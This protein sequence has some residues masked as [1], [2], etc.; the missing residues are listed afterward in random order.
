MSQ[1]KISSSSR[2][3]RD[4]AFE[5]PHA[6]LSNKIWQFKTNSIVLKNSFLF[7]LEF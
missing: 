7:I 2:R 1:F 5:P 6:S 4:S 3:R